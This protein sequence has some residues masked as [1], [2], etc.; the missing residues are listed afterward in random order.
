VVSGFF[1]MTGNPFPASFWSTRTEAL[2]HLGR[3][4]ADECARALDAVRASIEGQ[5]AILL[6]VRSLVAQSLAAPDAKTVARALG[7]SERT[8][9]RRLGEAGSSF[10][11][12]VQQLR[13]EAAARRLST[14]TTP[15]TTIAAELGFKTSQHFAALFREQYGVSP[16]EYR[17]TATRPPPS[18]GRD[19]RS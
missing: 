10:V 8:L 15:I 6:S 9:Q 3:E 13:L 5:P 7:M 11:A 12:V 17:A 2:A 4:D 14:E 1:A 19:S 18:T 16:T